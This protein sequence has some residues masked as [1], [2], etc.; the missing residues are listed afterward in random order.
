MNIQ[1]WPQPLREAACDAAIVPLFFSDTFPQHLCTCDDLFGGRL[2]SIFEKKLFNGKESTSFT[3]TPS[4]GI[5]ASFLILVGLGKPEELTAEVVRRAFSAAYKNT[6]LSKCE[7][8]GISVDDLTKHGLVAPALEGLLL[9]SYKFDKYQASEDA[10]AVKPLQ[11]I[12]L[13]GTEPEGDL[14]TKVE[15]TVRWVNYSRDLVNEPA[16]V[17]NPK[18]FADQGRKLAEELGVNFTMLDSNMLAEKQMNAI[19]AV[20]KGSSVPPVI[21]TL[22][23]EGAPGENDKIALVGK[24]LTFD[25]GGISIKPA[26][27]M[28]AMKGDMGGAAAV[29]GAFALIVSMKLKLNVYCVIGAAENMP[30]GTA[31]RPG[32]VVRAYN[33]KTIEIINTDAEGRVVLADTLAYAVKDLGA[34]HVVDVATLTGA[35]VVALGNVCSAI[36]T[37]N[38]ELVAQ[39]ETASR[40]SGE[41]V[42]RMPMYPEYKK[43]IK[44]KIADMKNTGGRM[45]GSITAAMLLEN[46][47][48]DKPWVHIDVA[49]TALGPNAEISPAYV[50]S[51]HLGTGVMVRTLYE[52]AR[53]RAENL[54]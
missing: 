15:N 39:I 9:A 23:Y 12:L 29:L 34:T 48:G 4:T 43:L 1:H 33:G 52:F 54:A 36:M 11:A 37:N 8:V 42:W 53:L 28:E 6:P 40:I 20:G 46:F 18:T 19:L 13:A 14:Q 51:S 22:Y 45:G 21:F 2:K 25:S 47:V 50:S 24:G 27:G 31:T 16:N 3:L 26:E 49:P 32:D 38:E 44:S 35:A 41:R 17:L 5:K 7:T 30:S 10:D